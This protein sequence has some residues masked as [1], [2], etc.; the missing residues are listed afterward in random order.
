[1][2]NGLPAHCGFTIC[3][4]PGSLLGREPYPR[5]YRAG[6]RFAEVSALPF[7]DYEAVANP[8]LPW[9]INVKAVQ[10]LFECPR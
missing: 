6:A 3:K 2:W 5:G 9:I 8:S 1:L 7:N 4:K 10:D